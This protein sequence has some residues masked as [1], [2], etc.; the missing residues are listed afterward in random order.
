MSSTLIVS[1]PALSMTL[2]ATLPL[3]GGSN[4]IVTAVRSR[5]YFGCTSNLGCRLNT[6][7]D[8]V[9]VHSGHYRPFVWT[10]KAYRFRLEYR[11]TDVA[12]S[13]GPVLYQ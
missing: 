9:Q 3:S 8:P 12:S 2:T 10:A 6:L 5:F 4:G 1:I 7:A 13:G 11:R